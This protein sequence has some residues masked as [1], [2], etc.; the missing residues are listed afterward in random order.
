MVLAVGQSG[1]LEAL[2]LLDPLSDGQDRASL[3]VL[4]ER[5]GAARLRVLVVGEAKRGKS[6]LINALLGRA[7]LP[8]G[9]TPLTAVETTA[10]LCGGNRSGEEIQVA[11]ASGVTR[12]YPLAALADFGTERGNPGNHRQVASITVRVDAPILHR[13]AEIVDTPGT[14]SVH[15]HNSAAADLA[16]PTMDAAIL[17]LSADPPISGTERDLLRRVGELSVAMFVVLN[18]ADYL[19]GAGSREAVEFTA[20]VAAEAMGRPV[21]VYPLS[22]QRA[23][24]AG[25]ERGFAEAS[26]DFLAYLDTA[27]HDD[28]GRAVSGHVRC[29][30]QLMHDEAAVA[31]RAARLPA[32][33]A[34][35]RVSAFIRKLTGVAAG[36]A[37]AEDRADLGTGLARLLGGDLAAAR[38]ADIER[39]ARARLAA[40]ATESADAWRLGQASQLEA[41][42]REIAGRLNAGLEAE[43]S[44]VRDAARDLLGLELALPAPV[45]RLQ[46]DRRFFSDVSEHVDQAELLAGAVRRRLPGSVG[47]RLARE[48]VR[49][50]VPEVADRL[51]GRARADLQYRLAEATRQLLADLR[52][53]YRGSTERLEAAVRGAAAIRTESA[54]ECERRLAGLAARQDAL[55]AVLSRLA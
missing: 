9:V 37:D 55:R 11:F 13:G 45:L 17:V 28:L 54:G 10:I 31:E 7:V 32:A 50:A 36:R 22:A 4:R 24:G 49:A 40:M 52:D 26:A 48:R 21:R 46:P 5:L 29:I 47:Q 23:L 8:T 12:R 20:G 53:R 3:A 30:A 35:E 42:L 2:D 51:L 14:G 6:T 44:E 41:G 19:G 33:A 18:K 38:A 25:S 15:A 39:Q 16:L 34:A 1:V 43:P 27:G